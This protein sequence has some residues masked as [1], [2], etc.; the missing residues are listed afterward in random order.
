MAVSKMATKEQQEQKGQL[1]DFVNQYNGG[2][3]FDLYFDNEKQQY[4][5]IRPDGRPILKLSKR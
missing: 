1:P 5:S 2:Y 3:F 4:F